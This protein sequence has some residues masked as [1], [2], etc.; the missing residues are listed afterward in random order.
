MKIA[1]LANSLV[2]EEM[3]QKIA[4][5]QVRVAWAESV[6]GLLQ[7]KDADAYF[8]LDFTFD[9]NRIIQLGKLFPKPVFINS[10]AHTLSKINHPFIRINAWTG[11]FTR[12]LCEAAVLEE[13]QKSV[14]EKIFKQMKWDFQFV[15]DVPGMVSARIVALIINEAYY[16]LED[17]VSTKQQIDIAMKLGTNYPFGPFEWGEK[18]GLKN[19]YDLLKELAKTESRYTISEALLKDSS[20]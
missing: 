2:K 7:I 14:A 9:D 17:Q 4:D 1:V 11:F 12:N 16:V 20:K 19:I 18:I 6:D 10:V 8:D 3:Q 15:P 5:A 13:T